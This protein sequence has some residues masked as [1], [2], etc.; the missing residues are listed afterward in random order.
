MI[1]SHLADGRQDPASSPWRPDVSLTG[2][3]LGRD[4][5]VPLPEVLA[6]ASRRRAAAP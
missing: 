2:A 3:C 6:R 1:E 4:R 5:A